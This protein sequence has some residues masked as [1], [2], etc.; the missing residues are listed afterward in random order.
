MLYNCLAGTVTHIARTR[1]FRDCQRF[2]SILIDG[3]NLLFVAGIPA[4]GFGTG[5]LARSRLGLLRF[6]VESLDPP[7]LAQTTVV[8]D[9]RGAPPGLPRTLTYHGIT[10]RFAS[11]TESAD[12]LIEELI[13][14]DTA[15]RQL[16]VVSSDHQVQR[17]ARRRRAQAVDSDT[18]HD[19]VLRRRNQRQTA[20]PQQ[21][22]K[23]AAPLLPDEVTRWLEQF[24]GEDLVE[25]VLRE[26][27]TREPP[28]QPSE[29]AEESKKVRGKR[30]R[31]QEPACDKDRLPLE[32]PF[33]PGYAE[34]LEE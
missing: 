16:T 11:R 7:E 12:E 27:R 31:R 30:R 17:A 28:S 14:A 15:P 9:A 18:W 20:R 6:L 10:V 29:L 21:P 32:N 5:P 25:Q 23:P 8:F 4:R 24:G 34:D 2:M 19:E 1:P 3:Y 33:P 26:E 13:E 22:A